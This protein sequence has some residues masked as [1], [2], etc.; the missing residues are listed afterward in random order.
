VVRL[1]EDYILVGGSCRIVPSVGQ[2]VYEK[3]IKMFYDSCE[4]IGAEFHLQ[5]YKRPFRLSSKSILVK[6]AQNEMEK[7]GVA[8][9][10]RTMAST[11]EASLFART[12]IECICI[13]IGEREEN[14]HTPTEKVGL[15]QI[16][17]AINF[18][19][20]MIERLSD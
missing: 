9:E 14:I 4:K 12:G 8:S 15:H 10:C 17:I 1:Y 13:G 5:D 7:L 3:W 11:N 6:S 19:E 20:K 18:Y 2:D 16:E